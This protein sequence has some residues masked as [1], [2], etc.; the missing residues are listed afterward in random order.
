MLIK[1]NTSGTFRRLHILVLLYMNRKVNQ[2]KYDKIIVLKNV[3]LQKL[4][5]I[6][7]IHNFTL[8]ILKFTIPPNH[9]E[10]N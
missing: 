7:L 9:T 10:P 1:A 3:L 5:R 8:P 4:P 6:I 2:I